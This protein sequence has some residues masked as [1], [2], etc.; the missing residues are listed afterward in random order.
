MK[1]E[2]KPLGYSYSEFEPLISEETII[3]HYDKLYR[4]Y[5]ASLNKV[6]SSINYD[7]SANEL[8]M[9]IQN[10]PIK[11]ND[12]IRYAGGVSNHELYFDSLTNKKTYPSKFLLDAIECSFGSFNQMIDYIITVTKSVFGSGYVFLVIEGEGLAVIKTINQNSPLIYGFYPLLAIDLWEHSYFLDYVNRRDEYVKSVI[13]LLNWDNANDLF[14]R[15][16][17]EIRNGIL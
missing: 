15:Y 8:L 12:I 6:V 4:G 1:Y 9:S 14:I 17:R 5:V 3:T 13:K 16:K 11:R 2:V 10:Y 7:I